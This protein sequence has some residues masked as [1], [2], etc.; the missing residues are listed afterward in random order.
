MF[1]VPSP[2]HGPHFIVMFSFP[3]ICISVINKKPRQHFY[4]LFR[5]DL[6]Q[7]QN[8]RLISKEIGQNG[9]LILHCKKSPV[10]LNDSFTF[11]IVIKLG[12]NR[13]KRLD[14]NIQNT[15]RNL[16]TSPDTPD[17]CVNWSSSL[18]RVLEKMSLRSQ[19]LL[20]S[21][22]CD[23]ILAENNITW[24]LILRKCKN[25][26]VRRHDCLTPSSHEEEKDKLI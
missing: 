9:L 11:F 17:G 13:K 5:L 1:W 2:Q 26:H 21:T 7:Y 14:R 18:L 20:A 3:Y 24:A 23:W 16:L 22:T 6:F 25:G 10:N 8:P 15:S 12:D 4:Q 19:F